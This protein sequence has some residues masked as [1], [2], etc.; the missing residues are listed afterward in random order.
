VADANAAAPAAI[1]SAMQTNPEVVRR[2]NSDLD[3][4]TLA[5][6]ASEKFP[7]GIDSVEQ[8]PQPPQ[9]ASAHADKT[10]LSTPSNE[11][12]GLAVGEVESRTSSRR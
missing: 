11:L 8:A 6:R 7:A 9:E 4:G 10:R 1:L 12:R 3:R 5:S 2:A